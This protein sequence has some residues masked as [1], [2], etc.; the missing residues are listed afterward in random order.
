MTRLGVGRWCRLVLAGN[1]GTYTYR[2]VASL[3]HLNFPAQEHGLNYPWRFYLYIINRE[4]IISQFFFSFIYFLLV[5]MC[6]CD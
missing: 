4:E 6:K 2:Q 3:Q 1:T 5:C